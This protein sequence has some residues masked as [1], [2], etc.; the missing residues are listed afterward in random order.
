MIVLAELFKRSQFDLNQR[1]VLQCG[2]WEICQPRDAFFRVCR[3]EIGKG[4]GVGE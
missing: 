2:I 1:Y 4:D 3:T